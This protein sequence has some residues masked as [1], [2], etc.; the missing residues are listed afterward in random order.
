MARS[1]FILLTTAGNDTGPF[2][3]YSSYDGY[4]TP[5]ETGISKAA[6]QGGYLSVLVPNATTIIQVRSTGVCTNFV[7]ISLITYSPT[8]SP[9]PSVS[10]TVTPSVTPTVTRTVSTT[11]SLTPTITPSVTPSIT[12][13]VSKTPSVS[14]TPSVSIT[15]GVS[16]TP[17]PSVSVTP[18]VSITPSPT[19]STSAPNV[20]TLNVSFTPPSIGGPTFTAT[21]SKALSSTIKIQNLLVTGYNATGCNFGTDVDSFQS[22]TNPMS[23]TAGN[24]FGTS[25]GGSESNSF[26]RT[27]V[28]SQQ[29]GTI[30]AGYGQITIDPGTGI[31]VTVSSGGTIVVGSTTVTVIVQPCTTVSSW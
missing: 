13:S 10:M 9:T 19:P 14:V 16:V 7:N 3:L 26:N 17:T 2:N 24:T 21:V 1:V 15:T 25:S 22:V 4:V 20:A 18:S 31:F 11:P 12:P 8:P 27:L 6:L 30:G 29:V 28:R 5:F 23:V